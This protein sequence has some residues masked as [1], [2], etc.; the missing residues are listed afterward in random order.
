MS[1]ERFDPQSV[2]PALTAARLERLLRAAAA[3]EDDDFGLSGDEIAAL[4]PLAKDDGV[5]WA[6]A[7]ADLDD[8]Q[9]LALIRLFTRAEERFTSWQAG[10]ASPVIPLAAVLKARGRYPA[11]LNAW[12]RSHSRNRFLPYG[13]L[14]DRL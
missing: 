1:V 3:S 14:L 6:A 2:K 5:D 8:A 13:S 12:I 9:L 10:A 7:G 11:D 4:A